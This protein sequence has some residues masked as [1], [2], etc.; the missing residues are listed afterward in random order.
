[1]TYNNFDF[2]DESTSD[3]EKDFYKDAILQNEK[4]K[5]STGAVRDSEEG[6][7][8]YIETISW[9]GMKRFAQYMTGKKKRYGS[10]NFKKGIPIESYEKSLVRHLQKYLANKYEGGTTEINEDHLSAILFNAF[11]IIHEEEREKSNKAPGKDNL[12]G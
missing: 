1:M 5:F 9:T 3:E 11:G 4:R 8:D 12:Q 7:E 2:D 6:K 10:G